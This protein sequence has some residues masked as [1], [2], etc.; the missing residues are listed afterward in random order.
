MHLVNGKKKIPGDE[1][2]SGIVILI[3]CCDMSYTFNIS[4]RFA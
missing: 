4:D 1:S 2:L 3:Y